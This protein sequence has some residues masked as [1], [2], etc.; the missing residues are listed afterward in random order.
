VDGAF[1]ALAYL[2]EI[3]RPALRGMERADSLAFDLHK[4]GYVPYDVGCALVRDAEAHRAAFATGA[5][6][7]TPLERGL[8]RGIR[9]C[10]AHSSCREGSGR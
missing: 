6:Y 3:L 4:W 1:G 2:S 10:G 8:W 9:V 7:L 5:S